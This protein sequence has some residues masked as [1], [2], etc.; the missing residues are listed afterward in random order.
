MQ[1][2]WWHVLADR[3]VY[4]TLCDEIDAAV[5]EGKIPATGN[6][7]WSEGQ[8]L[9]YFQACLRE[10]MRVRPAVGVDIVRHVPPEG[11]ELDGHFF[12]GGTTIAINGWALHRDK[13]GFGEDADDYRPE[14]WLEDEE[15]ARIMDRYM[16]QVSYGCDSTM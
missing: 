15:R 9:E 10:A 16:V 14:R 6:V 7:S 13:E 3:R 8:S 12:K 1:S 5:R 4:R 11:V 2:F